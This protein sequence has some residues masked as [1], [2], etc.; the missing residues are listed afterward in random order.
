MTLPEMIRTLRGMMTD[1]V[2][3]A[4]ASRL[5][6]VMPAITTV[7]TV[8]C[9]SVHVDGDPAPM[10]Y[11]WEIPAI[12]PKDEVERLGAEKAKNDGVRVISG[13]MT[14]GFGAVSVP[15]GRTREDSV[16]FLH[17]W[18]AGAL[19]DSLG[20]VLALLWTAGFL[21]TFLEPNSATVLFAKPSSRWVI[22]IGK[23]LGVVGFVGFQAFLF[24][25]GTWTALGMATGIWTIEY[26]LAVPLLLLNFSVFFAISTFLAVCTRSTVV[27]AFGTLL[28]WLLCWILNYSHHHLLL[29][30]VEGMTPLSRILLEAGYWVFPKPLDFS[31][32]FF[33]TLN[34]D[35]F[36]TKVD[37]FRQLQA[38]GRFSPEGAIASSLGFTALT[39]GLAG[40]ELEM[41]DY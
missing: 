34:A 37:E 4:F 12:M 20:V 19:G 31:G 8:F 30:P 26:W 17:V 39:L 15:V 38:S 36:T 29:N 16:R 28:I 10:T 32:I 27:T 24:V 2:R 14:L 21:P 41:T 40:Y 9:A 5:V 6:W 18:L 11:D 7:A 33:D 3:Q 23:Y 35:S 13:K 22:L 25:A 1:T